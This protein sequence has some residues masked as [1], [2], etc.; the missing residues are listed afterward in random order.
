M[1]SKTYRYTAGVLLLLSLVCL[2]CSCRPRH[3]RSGRGG[4]V[5]GSSSSA[6]AAPAERI[7]AVAEK[8]GGKIYL[9]GGANP[10][11]PLGSVY[12]YDPASGA[13]AGKAAMTAARHSSASALLDGG[14][15]V[16]GG[17]RG[18]DVVGTLEKFDPVANMWTSRRDM[19]TPRWLLMAVALKGQIYAMGGIAGVGDSRRALNVVEVYD[20]KADAWTTEKPMPRARESAAAAVLNDRV[21]I[22]SGKTASYAEKTTASTISAEVDCFDPASGSWSSVRSIPHPRTG[23]RAVVFDGLIHVVG[24]YGGNAMVKSVDVYDPKTDAWRDGPALAQPRSGHCCIELDGTI[25]LLGGTSGSMQSPTLC[26]SVDRLALGNTA[27]PQ[28]EPKPE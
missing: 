11:G 1:K 9:I 25:Y 18:N 15:Y 5:S 27:S 28:P 6:S 21:Y 12:E 22:I 3:S 19:P 23:A 4:G 17:R 13:W 26:P 20:P 24:G 2:L 7:V 10:Q 16:I 14:I 8:L